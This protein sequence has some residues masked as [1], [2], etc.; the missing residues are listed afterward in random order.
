MDARANTLCSRCREIDLSPVIF[1]EDH[2]DCWYAGGYLKEFYSDFTLGSLDSLFDKASTCDFCKMLC[3]T[4]EEFMD[5]DDLIQKRHDRSGVYFC[6]LS[7][8]EHAR[9]SI[10]AD[11]SYFQPPVEAMF[12][13]DI[14]IGYQGNLGATRRTATAELRN[15]F[16][17]APWPV[18]QL[19]AD[20]EPSQFWK[21]LRNGRLRSP[22]CEPDIL[23]TWLSKCE[24]SHSMCWWTGPKPSLRLRLFDIRFRCVRQFQIS[25]DNT[26]RYVALSYV[27]GSQAQRLTLSRANHKVLSKKGAINLDD[28]SRT[29]SDAAIVVDMLGERY[30]WVDAL[31]ILQ[32][33]QD[34]LAEQIPVMGQIYV[35]SLVTIMAAAS[36]DSNS[37]LPGVSTQARSA[38]R[39]SK[40]LNG[41]VL[42]R[43]CRPK[44]IPNLEPK[45][46]DVS[47]SKQKDYLKSSKWD[48]RGWTFQEKVL[49]RRCLYFMQEQ[50]YWE[51]QRASWCEETCLEASPET[52]PEYRFSWEVPSLNFFSDRE[53]P[54][55]KKMAGE[56]VIWAF[57][58]LIEEYTSRTLTR[59]QDTYRAFSGLVHI[60]EDL[61]GAKIF[62]GLHVS[63]FSRSLCWYNGESSSLRSGNEFPTWSW[64]AWTGRS[65]LTSSGP[66]NHIPL[67][68]CYRVCFNEFG[69]QELV[70]ISHDSRRK[71]GLD[72]PSMRDLAINVRSKLRDDFH[73]VFWAEVALLDV[74]GV[75]YDADAEL[76][77][78]KN[79]YRPIYNVYP[80]G[81]GRIGVQEFIR[82]R[83]EAYDEFA[84]RNH[85]RKVE[86]LM[87]S[88]KD[89]IARREA[90]AFFDV[91]EWTEAKPQQKLIVM[92]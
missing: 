61:T 20:G 41:G 45:W 59:K 30:L 5:A 73:I 53:F 15:M 86:L 46:E 47:S 13:M 56:D 21:T 4:L 82:I 70:P 31:C 88:W 49:S 2:P 52:G 14:D 8:S 57:S 19:K 78:S 34:D 48:T 77:P 12:R 66:Q 67:I 79:E 80:S 92:G 89:G 87:I 51:C 72:T 74:H 25:S 16:Q 62:Q 68:V 17:P 85:P 84:D 35:R 23:R 27:W 83:I 29:I 3:E 10:R 90:E 32:D 91:H 64:L 7:W 22:I 38:Q 28:I 9:A 50:L 65:T 24:S 6:G 75:R 55:G 54:I 60:L 42:L 69:E 71:D 39:I 40:P 1:R 33:D 63:E 36:I 44:D 18:P 11:V 81:H 26:V 43:T 76:E 37:G 58:R